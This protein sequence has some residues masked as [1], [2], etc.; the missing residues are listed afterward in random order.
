MVN[1][2]LKPLTRL[3]YDFIT[4]FMRLIPI[5]VLKLKRPGGIDHGDRN[6]YNAQ[7]SCQYKMLLFN[8]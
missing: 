5:V 1:F 3:F 6:G 4:V 8:F 2:S 7:G